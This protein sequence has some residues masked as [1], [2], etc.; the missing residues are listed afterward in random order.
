VGTAQG[1]LFYI[2]IFDG[3][4]V[5]VNGRREVKRS[6]KEGSAA[7]SQTLKPERKEERYPGP[8]TV[9]YGNQVSSIKI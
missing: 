1:T 8:I 2:G 7:E 9:A 5:P 4:R 6:L 3:E